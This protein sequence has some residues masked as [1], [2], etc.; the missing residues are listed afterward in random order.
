MVFFP[1]RVKRKGEWDNKTAWNRVKDRWIREGEKARQTD[2]DRETYRKKKEW[3]RERNFEYLP[4][5]F[6]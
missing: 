2:R 3:E 1:R 6:K 4:W 5:N